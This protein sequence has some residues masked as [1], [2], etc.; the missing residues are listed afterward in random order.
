RLCRLGF[1]ILSFSLLLA[2]FTSLLE[3][4]DSFGGRSF[5][6]WVMNTGFLKWVDAPI[7]WGCLVGTYLLWGRWDD[8]GWQ[9]RVGLL[10]VMGLIDGVLW[11]LEHGDDL[12]LQLGDVGHRW[13]RAPLGAA[14]G[15]A[16]FALLAS[17]AGDV[18]AHFGLEPAREASKS[19]RALAATGA[20][21]WMLLF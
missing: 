8:R 13:F 20:V 9:R 5:M 6:I 21:I 18:I 12:K 16:E 2:C 19:T 7:V 10:V 17:L 14:L 15:W 3:L 4:I 11:T 1:A